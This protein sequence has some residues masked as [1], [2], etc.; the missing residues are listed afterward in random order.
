M[1]CIFGAAL[2]PFVVCLILLLFGQTSNL[3]TIVAVYSVFGLP[4]VLITG[5]FLSL[6]SKNSKR[7]L[8]WSVVAYSTPSIIIDFAIIGFALNS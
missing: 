2:S 8:F 6:L 4:F 7:P 3:A 5:W 1:Y